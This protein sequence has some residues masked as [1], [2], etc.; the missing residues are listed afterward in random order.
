MNKLL[1]VSAFLLGVIAL[2]WMGANFVGS[3][4]L[5]VTVIVVIG[6]VYAIGFIELLQFRQATAT[7]TT[8]LSASS[9]DAAAGDA[10]FG[11]WLGKL[12]PSLQN[13]VRQ[14]IEGERVALPAPV[15]TP[16]L[17]GLLVMLGLLGTF[18]GMVETLRGAVIAL[19]G[20][21]ELQAIREGLTAPIKGLSLAF[22]TSVAG[23]AA[24][25]MLGLVSTL[26]RRDRMLATRQLDTLIDTTFRDFSLSHKRQQTYQA[27]QAQAQALPDV[28]AKLEDMTDRLAQ[29]GEQLSDKLVA[30]Q[31]AFHASASKSYTDL[32][33]SVDNSL[34]ESLAQSGRLAGESIAP[35]VS[36]AMTGLGEEAQAS[37]NRMEQIAREQLQA[38]GGEFDSATKT[39]LAAI[40][41]SSTA[42]LEQQDRRDSERLDSLN[43]AFGQA[44]QQLRDLTQAIGESSSAVLEQQGELSRTVS[45]ELQVFTR[46]AGDQ[47]STLRAEEE[48]RGEAAVERLAQLEETVARHLTSLG[49]ELEAPMARLIETAS[50]TPKAAAEV[51]GQLRQEISNNIERDNSLLE[52][53]RRIMDELNTLSGSLADSADGQRATIE[54]LVADS[55][56]VLQDINARFE[57]QLTS[58]LERVSNATDQFSG[59]SADL[60]S[61]GEAFSLAVGLFSESSQQLIE[62]LGLIEEALGKSS[63]RSD[64]Q[65]GYYVAQA[66]EIIDQS[67]LSQ[68]EIFEQLQQLEVEEQAASTGAS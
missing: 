59:S 26:S 42:L 58:Q 18:A 43:T 45:D 55:A 36:E 39:M 22:G 19:E 66:R 9:A 2:L 1:A 64:E 5:G 28:A 32:A 65:M 49:T 3:N 8:A 68:R 13:A 51:I 6:A 52:E 23:V 60:S 46:E 33:T 44:G 56:E 14:R 17:V 25:A 30:N 57:Q 62:R 47:L 48:R 11:G 41:D 15:I 21:T 61:L 20:T 63:E 27:L 67:M 29:M 37:Q 38:F 10:G 53:R 4:A 35:V 31:E 16:Y 7:L 24:S 54:K 40:Q 50:E 34:R 12:H